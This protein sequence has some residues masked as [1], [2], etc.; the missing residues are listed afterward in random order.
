M[1]DQKLTER[2]TTATLENT[3]LIHVVTDPGGTPT[4]KAIT[5]ADLRTEMQ[6]GISGGTFSGTS[7]FRLLPYDQLP[8][9]DVGALVA[10]NE[11]W[12][13]KFFLP[14]SL[15]VASVHFSINTTSAGSSTAIGVY[16]ADGNTL[17]VSSGAVSG[18][19][20]GVK[21]VTLGSPVTLAAGF[22][23]LAWTATDATVR[24][25]AIQTNLTWYG[26]M[27]AGTLQ[28]GKA[29]N[30]SASG[31]LPATLGA[32]STSGQTPVPIAKLQG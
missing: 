22:Y 30:A 2:P 16:S 21:S 6:E 10:A 29:A 18:A 13:V 17:H 8:P 24:F 32:I 25:S 3:D 9:S 7:A 27:I 14:M 5:T 23:W 4:T 1:A 20:G 15:T 31:V 26:I 12:V 11:V 19:S 28:E